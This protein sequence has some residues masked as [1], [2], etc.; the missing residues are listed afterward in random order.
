MYIHTP[1]HMS[2]TATTEKCRLFGCRIREE[3]RTRSF[4]SITDTNCRKLW[5][6]RWLMHDAAVDG[7]MSIELSRLN[8]DYVVSRVHHSNS[9]YLSNHINR[10]Q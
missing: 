10:Q 3:V 9:H 7:M 2:S 1:V 4:T 6:G 8:I 5:E